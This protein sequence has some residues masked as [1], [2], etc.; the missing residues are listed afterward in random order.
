MSAD[1]KVRSARPRRL[2]WLVHS[3]MVP[4]VAA[5]VVAAGVAFAFLRP[6]ATVDNISI[7]NPTG[8][9]IAVQARGTEGGWIPM[10]TAHRNRTTTVADVIDQGR[11]WTFRLTAQG[12]SAGEL[13][14]QR[15]ELE[16]AGCAIEIPTTTD[17]TLNDA[18]VNPPP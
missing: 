18:G 15:D 8:Y 10:S 14:I 13:H 1:T 2:R 9:D 5:A 16:A 7:T 6:P 11:V 4:V 17:E 12:Q 3:D